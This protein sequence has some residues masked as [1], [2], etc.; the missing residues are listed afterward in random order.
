MKILEANEKRALRQK[1]LI[2][3]Y[4]NS[5]ISFTLNIPGR[6]KDGPIY[7]EIH[8]EGVRSIKKALEEKMISIVYMEEED[9]FT[10]REAYILA[11]AQGDK[12][13]TI[14][15]EIEET[16]ELGRVFDIDVFNKWNCQINRKDIGKVLRRC[17]ICEKD[18]IIC[19]REK[20]HTSQELIDKIYIIWQEYRLN[21]NIDGIK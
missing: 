5:L 9:K 17:L 16:H 4:G 6:V 7:R 15:T 1:N 2:D 11:N 19:M 20:N 21:L 14:M 13:K 18:A 3:K 12:L 10:G 8:Q